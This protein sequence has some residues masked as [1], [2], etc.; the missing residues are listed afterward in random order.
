MR[1]RIAS[2]AVIL[3]AALSTSAIAQ[4]APAY[5]YAGSHAGGPA[6][7]LIRSGSPRAVVRPVRAPAYRYAG[8]HAGGPAN[9]LPRY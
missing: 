2:A 1:F 5:R 7:A 4:A 6:N 8:S 3:G 9:D